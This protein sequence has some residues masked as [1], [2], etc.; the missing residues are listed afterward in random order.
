LRRETLDRL[1]ARAVVLY[2]A[3]Q[4]QVGPGR[5]KGLRPICREIEKAFF[6]EKG[7]IVKLNY[8]T[9]R[10]LVQGG[11][12]RSQSNAERSW[13]MDKEVEAVI[14][15][16]IEVSAWGHGFSHYRLKEHVDEICRAR[17]GDK[18]PKTGVGARWTQR[19]V[20]KHSDRL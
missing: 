18:F 1:M 9:L 12:M 2:R 5:K 6:Q 10:N 15:Y 11:R 14:L 16:T 17:L 8:T 19:F 4:A 3:E 20:E 13:L 7:Q